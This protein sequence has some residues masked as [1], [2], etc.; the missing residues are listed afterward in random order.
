[1]GK[2]FQ[3]DLER[4]AARRDGPTVD[5][6]DA[7]ALPDRPDGSDGPADPHVWLDPTLMGSIV[8]T[9]AT[10]VA[11]AA[12]GDAGAIGRRGQKRVEEDV[13][14][15]AQITQSLESCQRRVIASQH[16][17]WGWFAAR[18]DFT[19]L[20]FDG[21]VPDDDPAPDPEHLAAI[22]RAI[23][24]G[25]VSTIFLETLSSTSYLEVIAD[26][27]GLDTDVLNPYEGL[28]LREDSNGASYRRIML[29]NLRVLQDQL[30]CAQS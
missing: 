22:E 17:A 20:G 16:E 8:T 26:E 30:D 5:V 19:S 15:D 2:G 3:P 11:A 6:L 21:V 9:I 25:S 18:Y 12:P 13:R 10:A 24:D 27:R 23:A 4:V 29:A 14:L 7:L 28:T 1:M